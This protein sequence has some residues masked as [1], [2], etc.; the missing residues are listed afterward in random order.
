M[1][2]RNKWG[3]LMCDTNPKRRRRY[4]LCPDCDGKPRVQVQLM[5]IEHPENYRDRCKPCG[6][7]YCPCGKVKSTCADCGG[8][9][10]CEHKIRRN[11]CK[12]CGPAG[13]VMHLVRNRMY[14][15]H[16]GETKNGHTIDI[17]GCTGQ[18]LRD[19]MAELCDYYNL[20]KKYGDFR[21]DKTKKNYHIDH[22]LPLEPAVEITMEELY[23]RL[24]WTNCRP[25]PPKANM[26]KGNRTE[27]GPSPDE[28]RAS[29]RKL[30]RKM[31]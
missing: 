7:G 23:K 27:E 20:T 17:L 21:F 29:I 30:E 31:D 5:C 12:E 22:F 4:C 18:E 2:T 26:A 10:M 24:H 6:K 8:G 9:S 1:V 14:H 25:M 16:R 13:H 28:E 19:R 3:H 15:A 11:E